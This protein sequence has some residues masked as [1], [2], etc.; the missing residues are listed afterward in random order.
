METSLKNKKIL[1]TAGPTREYID[2]VRFISNESSGKMGYA[3][4]E[5]LHQM[6]ADVIL[7]SGPVSITSSFPKNKIVSVMSGN[8]MYEACQ[9][10]FENIDVAIFCAAVADYKAKNTSVIKIKKIEN[11]TTL[12]LEK[13]VDIAFEFGK[14]K[15][16]NQK[17][18]GFALET[19]NIHENAVDKLKKKNFDLIVVNSPNV[20]EGFGYDTNKITIVDKN[21]SLFSFPLKNKKEVALD[22]LTHLKNSYNIIEEENNHLVNN[23]I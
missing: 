7:I 2:P 4:A 19:N 18:V 22:I 10:H 21:L 6:G 23:L 15:T 17:S 5:A 8:Q 20:N 1:I 11:E 12:E 16:E 3:I 13:N 14:V 9:K